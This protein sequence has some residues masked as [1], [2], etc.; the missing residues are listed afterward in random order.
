MGVFLFAGGDNCPMGCSLLYKPVCGSDGKT[1]GN[2][3]VIEALNKCTPGHQHLTMVA[4][5]PCQ[6][7]RQSRLL[8]GWATVII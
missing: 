8:A 5:V 3:C 7:E 6:G 4:P 1:Y 2:D